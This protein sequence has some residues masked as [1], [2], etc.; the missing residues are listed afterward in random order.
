MVDVK[1]EESEQKG[2]CI[3]IEKNNSHARTHTHNTNT[4]GVE[5]AVF[6]FFAR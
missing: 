3:G 6:P 5:R 4:G 1:K 2:Y